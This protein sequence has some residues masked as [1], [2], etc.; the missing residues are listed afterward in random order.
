LCQEVVAAIRD[1]GFEVM[2]YFDD[3]RAAV[4]VCAP[5]AHEVLVVVNTFGTRSRVDIDPASSGGIIEDHTHDPWSGWA[6]SSS[7]SYCVASLRKTLPIADG[8]V[9]WSPGGLPVPTAPRLSERHHLAAAMKHEGMLLKSL[10][11]EGRHLAKP[12]FRDLFV[13]GEAEIATAEVSGFHPVSA[14]VLDGFDVD[15]WRAKRKSNFDYLAAELADCPGF[16]VLSGCTADCCPFSVVLVFEEPIERERLRIG[17]IARDIYPS[18]LWPLEQQA[19]PLPSES[20]L[21]SRRVLS[22]H[23]DGRYEPSD[24]DRVVTVIRELAAGC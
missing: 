23:C 16:D 9:I 17:L 5:A 2:A 20:V 11:L 15:S 13:K 3:P 22:I 21:L 10:Y 4:E 8:G 14:A 6:M 7:A 19:V 24:L 1:E 12:I 18:V